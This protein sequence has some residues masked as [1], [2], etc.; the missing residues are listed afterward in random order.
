MYIV[1]ERETLTPQSSKVSHPNEAHVNM[2][3]SGPELIN[4]PLFEFFFTT[5]QNQCLADLSQLCLSAR[6]QSKFILAITLGLSK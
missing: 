4:S 2:L 1:W 6:W 5:E 3:I